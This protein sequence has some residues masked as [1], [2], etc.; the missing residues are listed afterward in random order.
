VTSISRTLD[1][2]TGVVHVPNNTSWF[3]SGRE[4]EAVRLWSSLGSVLQGK[5]I[6]CVSRWEEARLTVGTFGLVSER[7]SY[8]TSVPRLLNDI[9]S[10]VVFIFCR[11]RWKNDYE[12]SIVTIV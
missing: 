1:V 12:T 3:M 2:T 7:T 5:N 11:I 9:E 6:N 8:C 10:P 4:P